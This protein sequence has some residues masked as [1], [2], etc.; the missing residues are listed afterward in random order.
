MEVS[1]NIEDS[2]IASVYVEDTEP[3]HVPDRANS[4]KNLKKWP[5]GTSGNPGGRPKGT[6]KDYDRQRFQNMSDTEKD[7]F[8]SLIDPAFRYRMAEGN[9]TEDRNIKIT[10]PT[11]ILGG[12]SNML[13]M[14]ENK[15][16]NAPVTSVNEGTGTNVQGIVDTETH[17]T[18]DTNHE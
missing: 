17:D 11:P 2:E 4:L 14:T 16:L 3:E 9:P 15:A 5:K 6:L 12:A 10:V 13:H 7:A 8:L 1:Q 18:V